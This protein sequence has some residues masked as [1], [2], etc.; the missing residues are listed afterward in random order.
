MFLDDGSRDD[1]GVLKVWDECSNSSSESN[2]K[3]ISGVGD[4]DEFQYPLKRYYVKSYKSFKDHRITHDYEITLFLCISMQSNPASGSLRFNVGDASSYY[5]PKDILSIVTRHRNRY[6]QKDKNKAKKDK[7]EHE[8]GRALENEAES[9]FI[10]NGPTR[11]RL[12]GRT[13]NLKNDFINFQQRFDETFSEAWDRFKVLLRKCPHHGFSELLQIDMFYNVLTQFDQDSLNAAAGGNLLNRTPRDALTIIESKSNVRSLRNKPIVSKVS[14]TTSSPSP[15]PDV[16]ALTEIVKELVLMNKATQQATVKAIEETCVTCGGLHPYYECLATG[17]N[18]FDACAAVGTYNQGGNGYRP[19]GDPN[20]RA[21]NQMGPPGFSPPNVQNNCKVPRSRSFLYF[22][23]IRESIYSNTVAN[24]RGDLKAITTRKGVSYDGPTIPPTYSPLPKEAGRELE[25]TKDKVKTTSIAHVQPPVVQVPILEPDVAP[26]PN[27]KPLIP[28]PLRLT[29]KIECLALADLGASINLMPLSVWKKLS[30]LEL[31]PTRMTLEL[32]NRSIA[33]PVGVAEDVFVKVGK[34]HFLADFVVVDYD[35][36]PRVP[37]ILERPFL[38]MARALIDGD[39]FTLRKLLIRPFYESSRMKELQALKQVDV[40]MTKPSIEEPPELELKD[41]PPHLEYAF[42]EETDKLPVIISK[43]L[44]DEEK[45]AALFK[46]CMMAIFHD[47]IEEMMEVF[48]DDFSVFGDSLSSCLSHLDKMLKRCEDT[49]LVLNWEKCHFMVKEGIVLGHKILKSRIEVDRAKVDVIA[50]I[51][52]PTSI[53]AF[54]TLKK[55]LTEA[56]I[57]VSPDWYLPFEI[58]CDASDFTMLK[59]ELLQWILLLQGIRCI[60]RV[61]KEAEN[62]AA[63]HLSRLENPHQGEL[64]KKE[65]NE[66][67]PLETLRTI[68]FYGDSSTPWFANIANYH[69]GNFIKGCHLLSE[70]EHKA[71]WALKHFNFDLKS[72]GDHRKVKMNELNELWDQAYENSLIY[73]E[74][75]KKIHDSKI[76]NRVFNDCPDYKDSRAHGFVHRSLELQSLACLY[77]GIRYPRSY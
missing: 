14:T 19:Q 3:I 24:P 28:Y 23:S 34:F 49:N 27:P 18:T 15:S 58:M 56:P 26:K 72:A 17:G 68:S 5:Y 45:E 13:T 48:M 54:N 60:Y 7:T 61:I 1:I 75:T 33:Y 16:T 21:S 59:R 31:T 74:K 22:L 41:L 11:T 57:L 35:V 32:A 51:S 64:E 73:K 20:Y 53:K 40:T 37:L 66:T 38:R 6:P 50:K 8:I 55:K 43:E 44:K 71:Y 52:H 65:T 4:C 69:A 39:I 46:R 30:L 36:D 76:K 2:S 70:L 47:M 67:F 77:M 63:D 25:A 62:L 9:V 29:D 42:L 10:F 12:V